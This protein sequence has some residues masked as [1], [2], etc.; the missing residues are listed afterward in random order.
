MTIIFSANDDYSTTKVIEWLAHY[1][2][3]FIRVN[4]DELVT[5]TVNVNIQKNNFS[6][7]LKLNDNIIDLKKVKNIWYR[8]G[9]LLRFIPNKFQTVDTE[10]QRVLLKN[11]AFENDSLIDFFYTFSK[12]ASNIGSYDTYQLNKLHCLKMAALVG[13]NVPNS[14]VTTSK[15]EL[16]KFKRMNKN[17]ITKGIQEVFEGQYKSSGYYNSTEI[18]TDE[19]IENLPDNFFASL[20]QEQLSKRVEIRTFFLNNKLYSAAIFSQLD[21]KTKV[22]FRNYN[23]EKPNRMV[24]FNLPGQMEEKI[25][26]LMNKLNLNTGSIDLIYTDKKE[27]YFLEINPVGQ[28][29]FVSK[30]CNYNLDKKIARELI[31]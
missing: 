5:N 7:T 30:S 14:L 1:G 23:Y 21:P 10:L 27:F 2:A 16:I 24:V 22:D 8:G 20:F 19:I 3:N 15:E 9:N 13:L 4:S 11:I 6:I 25:C 17:I 29:D 28:Y 12:N 26:E 31:R 18:I